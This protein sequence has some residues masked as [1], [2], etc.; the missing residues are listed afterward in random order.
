MLEHRPNVLLEHDRVHHYE[1]FSYDSG[2]TDTSK[3]VGPYSHPLR[4]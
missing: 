2:V 1:D 3:S 4:R